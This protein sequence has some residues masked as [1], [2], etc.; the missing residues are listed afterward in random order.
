MRNDPLFELGLYRDWLAVLGLRHD[1][2]IGGTVDCVQVTLSLDFGHVGVDAGGR[3][4]TAQNSERVAAA[5]AGA[6]VA[7][8]LEHRFGLR[9]GLLLVRGERP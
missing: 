1:S 6:S 5:A 3:W 9:T 2:A 4:L 7:I 8:D